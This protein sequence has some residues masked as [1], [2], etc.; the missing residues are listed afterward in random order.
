M[1]QEFYKKRWEA[2]HNTFSLTEVAKR[3]RRRGLEMER[4]W[5]LGMGL[6]MYQEVWLLRI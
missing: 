2:L 5:T 3:K 1:Q 4:S 6:G